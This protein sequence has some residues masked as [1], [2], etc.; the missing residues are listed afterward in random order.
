MS[1]IAGLRITL[2][3]E[4]QRGSLNL[5]LALFEKYIE[6]ERERRKGNEK[7]KKKDRRQGNEFARSNIQSQ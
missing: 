4:S 1:N 6:E 5:A 3:N 2:A 7:E